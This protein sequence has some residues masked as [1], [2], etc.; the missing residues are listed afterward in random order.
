MRVWFQV[1]D[2]RIII[3]VIAAEIIFLKE[4]VIPLQDVQADVKIFHLAVANGDVVPFL[5]QNSNADLVPDEG[6]AVAIK[7]EIVRHDDD[8][9]VVFAVRGERG[10]L[11]NSQR[12][13]DD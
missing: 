10:V 9:L 3:E 2:V 7:S 8:G 4:K 1:L 12:T 5:N 13:G 11:K 6:R